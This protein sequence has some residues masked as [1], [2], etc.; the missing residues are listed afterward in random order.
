MTHTTNKQIKCAYKRFLTSTHTE[1]LDCY[2]R[3]SKA[4]YEA[5]RRC[6]SLARLFNYNRHR[7]LAYNSNTFSFGFTGVIDNKP[8]FFYITKDYDRYIFLD[9]LQE[10]RKSNGR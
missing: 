2:A 8:A 10:E 3:P 1:L 7:I 9:E 5:F 6:I 4:K